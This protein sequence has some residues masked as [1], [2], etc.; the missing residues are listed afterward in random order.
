MIKS[1]FALLLLGFFMFRTPP[2]GA[3]NTVNFSISRPS[4]VQIT[5]P[6]QLLGGL[7]GLVFMIAVLASFIF[8]V[9]GGVQWIISGG[10]KAGVEAAQHRIQAA[11]LGLFIVFVSWAIFSIAGKFLGFDIGN[12][13]IPTPF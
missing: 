2:V 8:L 13:S 10:D 4:I 3:V 11:L 12:I 5:D 1:L 6:S 9:W 7:I